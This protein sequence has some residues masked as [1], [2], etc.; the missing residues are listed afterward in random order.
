MGVVSRRSRSQ[1]SPPSSPQG[2]GHTETSFAV[3]E[4]IPRHVFQA[5]VILATVVVLMSYEVSI[6]LR[7][8]TCSVHSREVRRVARAGAA[9]A[10]PRV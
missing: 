3:F 10:S 9:R 1:S 8:G 6:A 2:S 7:E 5:I 4:G